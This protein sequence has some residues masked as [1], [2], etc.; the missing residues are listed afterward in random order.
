MPVS[1]LIEAKAMGVTPEDVRSLR[2]GGR[3]SISADEL[4]RLRLAGLLP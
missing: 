4:I 3:M 2:S 1:K